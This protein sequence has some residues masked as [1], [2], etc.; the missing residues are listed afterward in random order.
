MNKYHDNVCIYNYALCCLSLSILLGIFACRSLA[1]V[2]VWRRQLEAKASFGI[3]ELKSIQAKDYFPARV[4]QKE[5]LMSH[6]V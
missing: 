3:A 1:P 5:I 6:S 4:G 2:A